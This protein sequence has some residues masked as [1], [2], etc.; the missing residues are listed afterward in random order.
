MNLQN[1]VWKMI[2]DLSKKSG[3]TEIIINNTDNVYIEREGELIRLN[4]KNGADN[5]N[6]FIKDI[7]RLNNTEF[8]AKF[9]ILDGSLPDGSRI[10]IISSDFTGSAT[11]ITIRKYLKTIQSFDTSPGIFGLS[12]KMVKLL[13]TM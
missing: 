10:N 7:A 6:A 3:I 4:I 8:N 2:D 1:S 11:A 13:S 12:D 5:I 9:T